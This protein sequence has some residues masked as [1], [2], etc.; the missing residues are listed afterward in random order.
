MKDVIS[1]RVGEKGEAEF[2]S[3]TAAGNKRKQR[4]LKK[5]KKDTRRPLGEITATKEEGI[6]THNWDENIEQEESE[7]VHED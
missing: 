2:T 3:R 5:Q 6:E 1:F 4:G 7:T